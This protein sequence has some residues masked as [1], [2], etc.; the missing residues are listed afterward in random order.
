MSRY[1][2]HVK[3]WQRVKHGVFSDIIFIFLLN[4]H[5][6]QKQPR[7]ERIYFVLQAIFHP[8][9][10]S[11]RNRKLEVGG[12]SD[13]GTQHTSSLPSCS[14]LVSFLIQPGNICQ[15]DSVLCRLDSTNW[16][17]RKIPHRQPHRPTCWNQSLTSSSFCPCLLTTNIRITSNNKGGCH[18]HNNEGFWKC[19]YRQQKH[20][21][22]RDPPVSS[23][24]P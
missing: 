17:P 16:Q 5:H 2:E 23:L 8:W 7:E 11:G 21:C 19:G 15:A 9:G 6:G 22:L 20:A 14:D 4:K 12:G 13:G 24:N 10:K 3:S 1:T 18:W